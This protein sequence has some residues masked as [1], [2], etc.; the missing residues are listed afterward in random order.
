MGKVQEKTSKIGVTSEIRDFGDKETIVLYTE[1]N[2]IYQTLKE[3]AE[4]EVIYERW[5]NCDPTKA[6][7]VAVDLYFSRTSRITV[8]KVLEQLQKSGQNAVKSK[9]C[10]KLLKAI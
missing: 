8:K 6:S 4:K 7:K 10:Q 2:I 1:D 5:K 3:K 9:T